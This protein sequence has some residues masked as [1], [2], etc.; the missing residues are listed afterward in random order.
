MSSPCTLKINKLRRKNRALL[1]QLESN[2]ALLECR[3]KKLKHTA[4]TAKH[5][6]KSWEDLPPSPLKRKFECWKARNYSGQVS[7]ILHR[8]MCDSTQNSS[9]IIDADVQLKENIEECPVTSPAKRTRHNVLIVSNPRSKSSPK[10]HS[11][12]KS[13]T[14][15]NV[16]KKCQRS[17]RTCVCGKFRYENETS[18]K[19]E[20]SSSSSPS[21]VCNCSKIKMPTKHFDVKNGKVHLEK[22][23]LES[24]KSMLNYSP[25]SVFLKKLKKR[26]QTS[27]NLLSPGNIRKSPKALTTYA[28]SME[29]LPDELPVP[30]I[31][32]QKV[33]VSP[34]MSSPVKYA[35]FDKTDVDAKVTADI[36]SGPLMAKS[37]VH[38]EHSPMTETRNTRKSRKR[39][40][41]KKNCYCRVSQKKPKPRKKVV[42]DRKEN[43]SEGDTL[44][45]DVS[46]SEEVTSSHGCYCCYRDHQQ[47]SSPPKTPLLMADTISNLVDNELENKY[48]C[49]QYCN[50]DK[51]SKWF[52]KLN[53][54]RQSHYFD[55]HA[56][57]SSLSL[58]STRNWEAMSGQSLGHKCIHKYTLD[59]RLF[60]K[61]LYSDY[62][63]NS[64]CTTCHLPL[65]VTKSRKDGLLPI[66]LPSKL[67]D[68]IVQVSVPLSQSKTS[69]NSSHKK[70]SP[71]SHRKTKSPK[72]KSRFISPTIGNFKAW[73][74]PAD[75]LALRY[76]KG[77]MK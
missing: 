77:V 45:R 43:F 18:L 21:F 23:T 67:D 3:L 17:K 15:I 36:S 34:K 56:H 7:A 69:S 66:T 33:K 25:E 16:S 29:A 75:S 4:R 6:D 31:K 71:V 9:D 22:R 76:Q 61:P 60:A 73:M 59:D 14:I 38:S 11:E 46:S 32:S 55:C 8:D 54:F 74:P 64:R 70:L 27:E 57:P 47:K 40:C 49:G 19:E 63:N 10:S 13:S 44:E 52:N 72:T 12:L 39:I 26:S 53:E 42:E 65:E 41:Y 1:D 50:C 30:I 62:E 5:S 28:K 48:I 35:H 20:E 2:S 37:P 51:G 58:D 68:P 24:A